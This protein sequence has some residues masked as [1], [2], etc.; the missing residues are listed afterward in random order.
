MT[1]EKTG[2]GNPAPTTV[3]KCVRRGAVPASAVREVLCLT[4]N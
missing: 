1:D 3:F 2:P 4:A